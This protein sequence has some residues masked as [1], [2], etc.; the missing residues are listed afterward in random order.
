[1]N[2]MLIVAL[3]VGFVAAPA[4][5]HYFN[6]RRFTPD[7]DRTGT[8]LAIML[9]SVALVIGSAIVLYFTYL[10]PHHKLIAD[11]ASAFAAFGCSMFFCCG[12]THNAKLG[13][14]PKI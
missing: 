6:L 4:V 2:P 9:P 3:L 5:Y 10:D 11:I 13:S 1:M 12:P 8:W 14:S 7:T